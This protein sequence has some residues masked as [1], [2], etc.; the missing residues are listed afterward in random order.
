[1]WGPDPTTCSR[2]LQENLEEFKIEVQLTQLPTK[3]KDAIRIARALGFQYLWI[4]SLSI[5]QNS[6]ED[7]KAEALKMA[8]VYGRTSF[9]ISY[10]FPISNSD[11]TKPHLRDPRTIL[12]CKIFPTTLKQKG[13]GS[14]GELAPKRTSLPV[15]SL[16]VQ[17]AAKY[18]SFFWSADSTKES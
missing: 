12:P 3:Y 14:V 9:N 5:I 15:D 17:H 16:A 4:D 11:T 10:I 6:L 7:W 13:D 1:M 18:L 8:A 2:L